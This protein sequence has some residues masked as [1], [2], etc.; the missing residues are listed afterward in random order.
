[1]YGSLNLGTID[2]SLVTQYMGDIY[3]MFAVPIDFLIGIVGM[4]ALI[5]VL[6]ALLKA[7]RS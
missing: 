4:A 3:Q 1:M 7:F 2:M 6:A 5:G